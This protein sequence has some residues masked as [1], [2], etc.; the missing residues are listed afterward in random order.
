MARALLC[1]SL[2][3]LAAPARAQDDPEIRGKKVSEWLEQLQNDKDPRKRLQ[4]LLVVELVGAKA[5]PVVPGLAKALRQNPDA[6][7]RARCAEL[8]GKFKGDSRDAI[9]AMAAAMKEDKEGSVR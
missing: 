1:L 6:G 3:L 4:A 9:E 5:R 8:L 2:V 7:I